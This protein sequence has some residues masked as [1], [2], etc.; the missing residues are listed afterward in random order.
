MIEK[1]PLECAE[2]VCKNIMKKYVAEEL[3]PAGGFHYHQGVF[4]SGMEATYQ[5]VR[6]AAY[7]DYIKDYVDSLIDKD[8]NI[9]NYESSRLDDLQPGILLFRLLDETDD[10]RYEKVLHTIY[11]HIK[12]WPLNEE[13]GFY[14]KFKHPDQMWLDSLYM[15]GPFFVMYGERYNK[16]QCF[17]TICTQAILMWKHMRTKDSLLYHAWDASKKAVWAN[18]DTGLS[19]EVWGRAAGW[20]IVAL[21]NILDYIPNDHPKRCELIE[22]VNEYAKAIAKFQDKESGLWYQVVDKPDGEGNWVE[23][24]ASSLFVAGLSKAIFKGYLSEEYA[25]VC[26]KGYKG[27]VD[28]LIDNGDGTSSVPNICVGTDPGD[29]THYINRPTRD[30]D[31]HGSGAFLLMCNEY[32]NIY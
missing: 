3:P 11:N 16:P 21:C 22:I 27:L 4:L 24:S 1:K 18:A 17:D 26:D 32:H 6:K 29:Y 7:N 9:I 30:D 28:S 20:Y 31:L 8:G 5:R 14:H 2:E 25:P 19:S 15:G 13:G 23:H 10:P 12:D